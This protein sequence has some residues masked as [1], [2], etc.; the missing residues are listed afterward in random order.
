MKLVTAF[1][2]LAAI[3]LPSAAVAQPV[4]RRAEDCSRDVKAVIAGEERCLGA[5]EYCKAYDARDYLRYGFE[6]VG[7]PAR[8]RRRR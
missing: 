5:G 7:N 2:V 4:A 6:C 8:L 1:T 3:A